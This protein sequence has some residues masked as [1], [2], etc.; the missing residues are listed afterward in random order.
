MKPNSNSTLLIHCFVVIRGS[1]K[2]LHGLF[3]LVQD[4]LGGSFHKGKT[5]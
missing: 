3:L 2:E 1:G 5:Q 4:K